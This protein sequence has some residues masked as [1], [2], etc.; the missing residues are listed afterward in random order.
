MYNRVSQIFSSHLK[1]DL[2]TQ[3]GIE[4]DVSI[5]SWANETGIMM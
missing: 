5:L 2:K 3:P 1:L 4:S